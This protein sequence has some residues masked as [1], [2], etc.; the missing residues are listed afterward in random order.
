MTWHDRMSTR[1][2]VYHR[3]RQDISQ[4]Y[5]P[6][7]TAARLTVAAFAL[8]RVHMY[9]RNKCLKIIYFPTVYYY[10]YLVL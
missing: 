6:V 1:L 4:Y 2:P 9:R 7:P 5:F 10:E 3:T 8:L